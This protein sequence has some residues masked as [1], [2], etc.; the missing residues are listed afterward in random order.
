MV[1]FISL[2][3][4]IIGLLVF[5]NVESMAYWGEDTLVWFWIG[6]ILAYLCAIGALVLTYFSFVKQKLNGYKVV[7]NFINALL[8]IFILF[9]TS[10]IVIIW[11]LKL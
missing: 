1:I 8:S 11:S 2:A 5:S 4:S 7:L 9:G 3:M 6:A 10:A